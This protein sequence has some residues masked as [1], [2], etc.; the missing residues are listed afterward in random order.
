MTRRLATARGD[1]GSCAEDPFRTWHGLRAMGIADPLLDRMAPLVE[2]WLRES[3]ST[4]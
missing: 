3:E 1:L 4:N 2:T